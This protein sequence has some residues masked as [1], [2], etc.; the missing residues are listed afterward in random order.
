MDHP[1]SQPSEMPSPE[2][3]GGGAT[4][5]ELSKEQEAAV[6][7][8]ACRRVAAAVQRTQVESCGRLVG[9]CGQ[10]VGLRGLRYAAPRRSASR[11]LRL[12]RVVDAAGRSGGFRRPARQ[13][14]ICDFRPSRPPNCGIC[15]WTYG[16]S[17]DRGR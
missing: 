17:G 8:A 14:P 5:P 9:R 7:R 10:D 15:T 4:R 6:F 16:F 2:T 11:L 1:S 12:H 13:P 3:P